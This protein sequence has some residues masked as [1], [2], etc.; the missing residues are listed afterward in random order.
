MT[1]PH[2][3][4]IVLAAG[5]SS[6]LGRPKQLLR[7]SGRPLLERTLDIVGPTD[8][9]PRVLVLGAVADEIEAEVDTDTFSVV[10]NPDYETGQASSL[11]VGLA[12]LPDDIDGAIVLLGDQPL[13][14]PWLLD[15][16]VEKFEPDTHVAVRPRYSDGPGNPV[17][18]SRSIFPELMHLEGDVGARDVLRRHRDA[19]LDIDWS[20][21]RAPRDVDTEENYAELLLD[22]AAS[23][24]PDPPRFCQRCSA[25]IGTQERHNRL[26]PVCPRCGFTYFHDPKIAAVVV[27]EIDGKIVLQQRRIDP[28]RGKWTFP[29]G[30]VDRGEPIPVAAAREVEEE[31]GLRIDDLKLI[32]IYSEPGETVVLAAYRATAEGQQPVCGDESDDVR[33]FPPDALP[34]LAFHRDARVIADWRAAR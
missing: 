15:A 3:G 11:R 21:Y 31:V 6:R 22:W 7:V 19:I 23:G 10:R 33:L 28:G 8:L 25:E 18:L 34:D 2:V 29:G 20:R 14:Q 5:S 13:V 30:F 26:R 12:A 32:G 16:L 24:A 4:I 9:Y 17:L 27:V 1:R